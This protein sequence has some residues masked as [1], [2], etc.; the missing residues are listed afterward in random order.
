M[1]K[2]IFNPGNYSQRINLI[3]FILRLAAGIFMLTHG[4]G[5]FEK[6]F[7]GEPIQF[8]NPIGMG[9][10]TSLALTVFAEVCCSILLIFGLAT[11]FAAVP[12]M[13]TMLVAVFIVHGDDPFGKKE[14]PSLYFV[15]YTVIAIAGAGKFSLDHWIHRK[16]NN[17]VT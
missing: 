15:V 10:T 8:A 6:L 9:E 17:T 4:I 14:L 12:L 16:M 1:I 5:K 11:R 3:L 2:T 7:S 13:I